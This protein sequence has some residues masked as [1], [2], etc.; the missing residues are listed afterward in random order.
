MKTRPGALLAG[1][2]FMVVGSLP[3]AA[4]PCPRPAAGA[5]VSPPPDLFGKG[6]ALDVTLDYLTGLDE[7]SRTLFCFR[8]PDGTESP[9]LRVRPGG[10]LNLTVR[11]Q[12]PALPAGSPSETV[13]GTS[14]VCGSATMNDT[15]VNVHFHGTNTSPACGADQ[16]IHT[17]INSGQ[18]FP[19]HLRFPADEP[20]G[21][22]WYH[23]HVH[24]IAEAAV[25]GGASGVIVVEGIENLEP[26]LAGLPERILIFR[27][28]TV[29]GYPAPGGAVPSWDVSL[30][31]VPIAYPALTPAAIRAA[32]HGPEFWR[33]ANAAAD[34]ILDLQLTY[35]GVVQPLDVVALDGV[36]TGSQD[37]ARRGHPVRVDHVPLPPAG[38]AEFV[39]P[40]PPPGVKVAEL[41]TLRID[42]GPLGDND[43]KRTLAK[44]FFDDRA[45][46][47]LRLMPAASEAPGRQSYEGLDEAP[48]TAHRTLYFSEVVSDPSNPA[49]PTNFYI[50]VDGAKP[51]L[52][53]PANPPA[54][55]TRAGAVEDWTI[56]NRSG[57]LHVFHLHQIHF[58]ILEE[59]GARVPPGERQFRDT[60]E[61][62]YWKGKGPYPSVTARMDFRG[63]VVGDYVYH[64]HILGH[65]D[66]GM[67]AI[68]RVLPPA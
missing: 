50:T 67:M 26:R 1:F 38:R 2:A 36:S 30:N 41:R 59:D 49:S 3:A 68:I 19:Y 16:A 48:V 60:V 31:Y 56:E 53:D 13:S 21:L 52:F 65:E 63:M 64:C 37:G 55:V 6:G 24:G 8:T 32:G 5:T 46:P 29:A 11:N 35:D 9:T 42:T 58:E 10:E 51:M 61:V 45:A 54:I 25:Q 15:S 27:D 18:V 62:P 7:A 23:P 4:A 33:V 28:Q 57:E 14:D 22:Y 43:P 44:V 34:T 12:V 66:N 17:L 40:A 20:P 47:A 39:I